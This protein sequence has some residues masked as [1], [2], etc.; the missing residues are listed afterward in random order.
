MSLSGFL[1]MWVCKLRL[2]NCYELICLKIYKQAGSWNS[3]FR[4]F[5][6]LWPIIR[7]DSSSE[8]WYY[9][10]LQLAPYPWKMVNLHKKIHYRANIFLANGMTPF[11]DI[12]C[13]P[14][15]W[16]PHSSSSEE[17]KTRNFLFMRRHVTV[18]I[19]ILASISFQISSA[20]HVEV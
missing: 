12:Q 4:N 11:L 19:R 20:Q 6:T 1:E 10:N 8:S 9:W 13:L 15:Y 18:V 2:C 5:Q 16:F 14:P 3:C 7:W 17:L